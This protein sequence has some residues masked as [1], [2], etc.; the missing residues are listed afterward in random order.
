[1]EQ[2]EEG[3]GQGQEK[4]GMD[5][6]ESPDATI[7]SVSAHVLDEIKSGAIWLRIPYSAS[8]MCNVQFQNAET[9][10]YDKQFFFTVTLASHVARGIQVVLL[11]PHTRFVLDLSKQ[12]SVVKINELIKEH[13]GKDPTLPQMV[14]CLGDLLFKVTGVK[15]HLYLLWAETLEFVSG[16][17][18]TR[19][20]QTPLL[21]STDGHFKTRGIFP[22]FGQHKM[23]SFIQPVSCKFVIPSRYVVW[24][25][26]TRPSPGP[27]PHEAVTS[28]TVASHAQRDMIP[29]HELPKYQTKPSAVESHRE[30]SDDDDDDPSSHDGY[31]RRL[32]DVYASTASE[33]Y[34][35][36]TLVASELPTPRPF[37]QTKGA[38][39]VL[40]SGFFDVDAESAEEATNRPA[41][42][43]SP[44]A[45][46]S[47]SPRPSDFDNPHAAR[48]HYIRRSESMAIPLAP[49]YSPPKDSVARRKG[50]S[51]SGLR[52]TEDSSE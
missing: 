48:R 39:S 30:T 42:A 46:L 25:L 4:D 45:T 14:L 37:S 12:R 41:L 22:M 1:V 9:R 33:E 50:T 8:E 18:P 51:A 44:S 6:Q 11:F 20:Y 5:L 36:A 32:R 40:A 27:V 23:H 10:V 26:D 17:L 49:L 28:A 52:R 21:A 35:S 31:H 13:L 15:G 2:Q 24:S 19:W 43:A 3:Q 16:R 29:D 34:E 47:S 7:P 38:T